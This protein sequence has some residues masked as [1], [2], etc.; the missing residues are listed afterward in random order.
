[1]DYFTNGIMNFLVGAF[2]KRENCHF[3]IAPGPED[4][5]EKQGFWRSKRWPKNVHV[6]S[7]EVLGSIHLYDLRVTVYGWG[8]RG[9]LS[10][11][12][13]F[14][15]AHS[16]PKGHLSILC[17]RSD[18]GGAGSENC[19]I[20]EEDLAAFGA[21][22]VALTGKP[23]DGFHTVG[24]SVYAYSGAFQSESFGG[25]EGGAY[26][27]VTAE[28]KESGWSLSYERKKAD[29]YRCAECVLDVSHADASSAVLKKIEALF[30]KKGY[31]EKTAVLLHLTGNVAPDV[32]FGGWDAVDFGVYSL[33]VSDE[34]LPVDGAE[35]LLH[36]MTAAGELYRHFYTAMTQGD[37][38]ARKAAARAFRIGYAAL[39]G[40]DFTCF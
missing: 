3:I 32:S 19:P 38:E 12:S 11:V 7:D 2:A 1:K 15:G 27:E 20:S 22:Y 16:T 9:K 17:G 26:V 14:V 24:N 40:K 6:F 36:E 33:R 31:D 8:Y 5:F 30:R 10:T 34:T 18:L 35:H 39:L 4:F 37:V 21:D 25:D 29:T 13:P 28:A 23:H